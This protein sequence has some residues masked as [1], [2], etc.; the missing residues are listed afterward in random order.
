MQSRGTPGSEVATS[1]SISPVLPLL[2]LQPP[3]P[4]LAAV[5][6]N[7]FLDILMPDAS[8]FLLLHWDGKAERTSLPSAG[9][10]FRNWALEKSFHLESGLLLGRKLWGISQWL[11]FLFPARATRGSFSDFHH[12][13]LVGS[14]KESPHTCG[15]PKAVALRSFSP[16]H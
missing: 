6:P 7:G 1:T 11:L 15:A 3:L 12:K 10:K 4:S 14:W 5:L 13:N 16:S 9:I 8:A 2:R